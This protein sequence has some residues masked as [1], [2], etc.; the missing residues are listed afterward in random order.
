MKAIN[1]TLDWAVNTMHSGFLMAL[2]HG[3]YKNAGIDLEIKG[4]AEGET[5]T[6]GSDFICAPQASYTLGLAENKTQGL[7]AI[8]SITQTNDSGIVSLKKEGITSP[9][10]L[11]GKRLTHWN[12]DWFHAVLEQVVAE[13][14]GD[15]KEVIKVP[16]DVEHI[17]ETLQTKADATW[18]YKSWEYFELIDAG[19]EVNYFSFP[20]QNPVFDYC[21]PAL[22]VQ[23]SLRNE[24]PQLVR[25]FLAATEK[26]YQLAKANPREAVEYLAK[27]RP[28]VSQPLWEA[29]QNYI[30][31]IYLD[32]Q[33]HWGRI[34]PERWNNFDNW[35]IEKNLVAKEQVIQG[36]GFTNEYF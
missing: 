28:E 10:Q 35:M 2:E 5:L 11:M 8:A 17:V 7:T 3:L 14:G 4:S 33:G 9:K 22:F 27:R 26:G 32:E 12:Q 1:L 6:S 15:Y 29:S 23:N 25:S 19:H 30:S 18:V 34:S 21:S 36:S 13:D 16:M 24:N 31:N 20:Q